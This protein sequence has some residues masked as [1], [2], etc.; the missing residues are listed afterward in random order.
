MRLRSALLAL[1]LGACTA[2]TT[3]DTT[4]GSPDAA[5]TTSRGTSGTE[6]ATLQPT[7]GSDPLEPTPAQ[8]G[9]PFYP[10]EKPDDRDNDLVVVEGRPEPASGEVLLLTGRLLAT[11]GAPI[12][13]AVVEIW[14][15]DQNGIYLHPRDPGIDN[16][17]PNFQGYGESVTDDNGDWSFR[18]VDPGYYEPRPRHIHL[19]VVAD[20]EVVLTSQ[21]YFSDDPQAG[22]ENPLLIAEIEVGAAED[23]SSVLMASHVLVL[24]R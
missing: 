18:T 10:V 6:A 21:I 4:P 12:A 22:G 24:H 15:V 17:D 9:G 7:T 16:R 14:Q 23:G 11:D 13:G 1:V 3:T 8:Q 20:G 2:V 5:V 19:R